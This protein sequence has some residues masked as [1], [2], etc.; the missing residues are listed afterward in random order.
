MVQSRQEIEG[1]QKLKRILVCIDIGGT[2]IKAGICDMEGGLG[3]QEILPIHQDIEQ[4][5]EEI[6]KYVNKAKESGEMIGIAMKRT[7]GR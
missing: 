7:E 1:E 5:L 6:G 3:A 2:S 4:L